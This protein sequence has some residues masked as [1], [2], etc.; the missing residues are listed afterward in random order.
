VNQNLDCL[1]FSVA[2]RDSNAESQGGKV[3]AGG[4]QVQEAGLLEK[5]DAPQGNYRLV[6]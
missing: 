3:H 2:R 6:H 1:Y 5:C 4:N